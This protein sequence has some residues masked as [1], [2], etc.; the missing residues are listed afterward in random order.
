MLDLIT[1]D[2]FKDIVPEG[3]NPFVRKRILIISQT[4]HIVGALFLE[5]V[6][7]IVAEALETSG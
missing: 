4:L 1:L 3:F 2:V 5:G 6:S 7:F